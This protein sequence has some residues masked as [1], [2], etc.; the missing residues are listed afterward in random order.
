MFPATG[1]VITCSIADE[2][3]LFK[4]SG[5]PGLQRVLC[6]L[7]LETFL[8]ARSQ[9][10]RAE[11]N[12]GM[13]CRGFSVVQCVAAMQGYLRGCITRRSEIRERLLPSFLPPSDWPSSILFNFLII[14]SDVLIQI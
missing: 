14:V 4:G 6:W 8:S 11:E 9:E 12:L 13:G 2:V 1:Q 5:L 3:V 7:R 10:V